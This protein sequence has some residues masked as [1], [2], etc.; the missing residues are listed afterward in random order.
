MSHKSIVQK[1]IKLKD[2]VKLSKEQKSQV[3]ALLKG[4]QQ[5]KYFN[6]SA[7]LQLIDW[8]GAVVRLSSTIQGNGDTQRN[9]D[10]IK[11]TSLTLSYNIRNPSVLAPSLEQVVRV[12]VFRWLPADI[13][14]PVMADILQNTASESAIFT[15]YND[16]RREQFEVLYDKT[17]KVASE[18][19]GF[20]GKSMVSQRYIKCNKK[21]EYN[22]GTSN[23]TSNI[24]MLYFSNQ[25]PAVGANRGLMTYYSTLRY[26]N[27]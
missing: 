21:I 18:Q 26:T 19:N 23:G 3:K 24:Y 1:K 14:G 8:A 17:H 25:D 20:A 4:V 15:Q 27:S 13:T 16:D 22:I 6:T 7:S 11:C 2:D 12:I 5:L 10:T 9:G